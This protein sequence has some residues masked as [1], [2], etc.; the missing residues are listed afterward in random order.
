MRAKFVFES[1]HILNKIDLINEILQQFDAE[2]RDDLKKDLLDMSKD[3]FDDFVKYAGYNKM[4]KY[5]T[6]STVY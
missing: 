1:Q 3:E 4:G 6:A 5:W 2:I